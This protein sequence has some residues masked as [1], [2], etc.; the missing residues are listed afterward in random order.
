[1]DNKRQKATVKD[2]VQCYCPM[3]TAS[4]E[5]LL[6]QVPARVINEMLL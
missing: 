3:A 2:M 5:N 4:M 6:S 1:M